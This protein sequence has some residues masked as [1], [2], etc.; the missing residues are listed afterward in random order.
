MAVW[1]VVCVRVWALVGAARLTD[2]SQRGAEIRF[3]SAIVVVVVV[4]GASLLAAHSLQRLA[5]KRPYAL[6]G[7]GGGQR[8]AIEQIDS[9]VAKPSSSHR[10]SSRAQHK[11]PLLACELVF[12]SVVANVNHVRERPKYT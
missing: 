1:A 11:N 5:S 7:S 6:C 12:A 2:K 3:T 10:D 8:Q 9:N 4:V